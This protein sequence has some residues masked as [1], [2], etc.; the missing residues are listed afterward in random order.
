[1]PTPLGPYSTV[2]LEATIL[3]DTISMS[4]SRPKNSIASIGV[5]VNG[6]SPLYGDAG[7]CAHTVAIP[8]SLLRP[9][10]RSVLVDFDGLDV[11]LAP[12]GELE[13]RRSR[14]NGPGN[15]R[16]RASAAEAVHDEPE[17]PVHEVVPEEQQVA[18]SE[19][20]GEGHGDRGLELV[21]A[22]EVDVVVLS[23][24]EALPV[25]SGLGSAVPRRRSRTVRRS[26]ERSA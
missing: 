17:I 7:G 19:A 2:S 20:R 12:E 10:R 5:S 11:E 15:V 13:L 3:A 14:P 6:E 24:D 16:R 23:D 1:M 21:G 8:S 9:G 22:G 26:S 25:R 4:R 18:A